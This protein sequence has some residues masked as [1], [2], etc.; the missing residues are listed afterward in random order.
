VRARAGHADA[1]EIVAA[2]VAAAR[3]TT[4][5]SDAAARPWLD[6]PCPE[7]GGARRV[8]V[9]LPLL[10]LASTGLS[11]RPLTTRAWIARVVG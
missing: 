4:G 1:P 6:Q 2:R 10:V 8:D 11:G 9:L 7:L 3:V 5:A